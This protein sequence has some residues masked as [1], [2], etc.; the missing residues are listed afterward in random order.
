VP[1]QHRNGVSP[2]PSPQLT[3][4]LVN[5]AGALHITVRS[6]RRDP[7]DL[8]KLSRAVIAMALRDAEG[9]ADVR[10][11]LNGNDQSASDT[12]DDHGEAA[13]A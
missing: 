5:N 1:T 8:R 3:A 10:D 6:V 13:S 12:P 9:E 7:P 4:S 2:E 11:A